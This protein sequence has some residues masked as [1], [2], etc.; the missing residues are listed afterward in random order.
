MRALTETGDNMIHI[1]RLAHGRAPLAQNT[2]FNFSS[3]PQTR[4]RALVTACAL[5]LAALATFP[6]HAGNGGNASGS[7]G[8][9]AGGAGNAGGA[10]ATASGSGQNGQGVGTAGGGAGNTYDRGNGGSTV[11]GGG[12]GSSII[13]DGHTATGGGGGA[14][15]DLSTM[16]NGG[17]GG[18]GSSYGDAP[19][20]GGGGG[21][22]GGLGTL[23]VGAGQSN[24]GAVIGGSGGNGYNGASTGTDGAGGGAGGGGGAGALLGP[25]SGLVNNGNITGGTGGNGGH[26][27]GYG[28]SSGGGGGG[29]VGLIMSDNS[30]LVNFGSIAGGRAGAGDDGYGKGGTA[31]EVTGHATVDNYGSIGGG[32]QNAVNFEGVGNVLNLRAGSN[33]TGSVSVLENA[34]ATI[35]AKDMPQ[36]LPFMTF[37]AKGAQL[38]FDTSGASLSAGVSGGRFGTLI[39]TGANTLTLNY[40]N[41]DTVDSSTDQVVLNN[42]ANVLTSQTWR[43]TVTLGNNVG[44]YSLT[45]PSTSTGI[46]IANLNGGSFNTVLQTS[47]GI[48]LGTASANSLTI[49]GNTLTGNG[50][51]VAGSVAVTTTGVSD[52]SRA[53]TVS[54]TSSFD[55]KGQAINLTHAGNNFTGEVALAGGAVQIVD[56]SALDLGALSVSGLNATSHGALNL[57][58]GTI[59]GAL[60][61]NSNGGNITQDSALHVS[62]TAAANAGTGNVVLTNAGNVFNGAMTLTG[63]DIT[64]STA[65]S[66][67]LDAVTAAGTFNLAAGAVSMTGIGRVAADTL[68]GQV[69]GVANFS[70]YSQIA[71]LGDFT[72]QG[73]QLNNLGALS[74]DGHVDSDTGAINITTDAH[75]LTLASGASLSGAGVTLSSQTDMRVDGQINTTGTALFNAPGNIVVTGDITADTVRSNGLMVIGNGGTTGS[76]SGTL[77]GTY[78]AFNRSDTVVLDGVINQLNQLQQ[79]GSGTLVLNGANTGLS[80]TVVSAGTLLVG[81][82]AHATSTLGTTNLVALNNATV[83]GT[84]T[85]DGSVVVYHGATLAP[86]DAQAIG[87]LTI[88]GDLGLNSGSQL[89]FDLGAASGSDKIQGTSDHLVV[90]GDLQLNGTSISFRDAGGMGPGLYGL[91]Q[92]GGVLTTTNGGITAPA[93]QQLRTYVDDK[94]IVLV[95]TQGLTLDY[96]NANGQASA[97]ALGGGSGTWSVVSSNWTDATG[98][99]TAPMTPQPGFAIFGGSAGTVT[100]DGSAGQ[101]AAQGL[102]FFSDGYRMTGDALALTGQNGAAPILRVSDGATATIDNVLTGNLGLNKTDGGTLVLNG[103]NSYTG[104]TTLSGGIVSVATDANLGAATGALHFDGGTLRITGT[105]FQQT[106][107]DIQWGNQG[108]G[109][110]IAD[111]NNTFTV[112]QAL[113]GGAL[114]KSG[115]GTLVLTGANTY[116]GGTEIAAGTLQGDSLSLQGDIANNATLAFVQDVDGSY[117]GAISGS[118]QL[119]KNG[120]GTLVLA[121]S[122]SYGGGTAIEDGT[123]QGDTRSLQGP[124]VNHASLVFDQATSGIFNG[125]LSGAGD[126]AKIGDGALVLNGNN[127]ATGSFDVQ[128]GTLVMGDDAHA[129]ASYAGTIHIDAGATLGGIGTLGGLSLAGTLS[130]G[131]SVGTLHVTGDAVLQQGSTWHIEAMPDGTADALSVGGKATIQG[132]TVDIVAQDGNWQ[133]RTDYTLL[134]ADGGISGKFSSVTTNLAFLDPVLTYAGNSIRMSLERNDIR[135]DTVGLTANQRAV[136]GAAEALGFGQA[137][138]DALVQQEAATARAGFT[139]LAG[140]IHASTRTAIADNERHVREAIN[141]HLLGAGK[142]IDN[143]QGG[144]AWTSAWGH[145]GHHD[146]DGNA[147]DLSNNGSGLLVGGD[148][149]IGAGSR[150]GAAIGMGQGSASID[151]QRATSHVKDKHLALY[152]ATSMGLFALQGGVVQGWQTIDTR[153]QL[154]FGAFNGRADASYDASTTQAYADGSLRFTTAQGTLAPFANVAWLRLKTDSAN[155]QGGAAALHVMDNSSN[156]TVGTLGLRAQTSLDAQGALRLYASAGWQHAWGDVIPSTQM[157]FVDGSNVFAINGVALARNAGV[158]QGGVQFALSPS[159]SVNATYSGQFA[160]GASDQAARMS[161]TWSF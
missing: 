16:G 27:A 113:A 6:A 59:N 66:T 38:T 155:E 31:L 129:Q 76:V 19:N 34:S 136:A 118:G 161:L 111:A 139:Q 90:T 122:N 133:P 12:G 92:W 22:G 100:V 149:A 83:G 102:Q 24:A 71:H 110:D 157:R 94:Q 1:E 97:T 89:A 84:G 128:A 62:G 99:I 41:V 142:S 152:G 141:E 115:S 52:F 130:P 151:S 42:S 20:A 17:G 63:H 36:T 135:F 65:G 51:V 95:D 104:T 15:G 108:G 43:G 23:F 82:A 116:T 158:V 7:A 87:T 91:I 58:Q 127:G 53:W 47:G 67:T 68:T 123:L 153:R 18:G 77:T 160:S 49:I 159:L 14:G 117:A 85:I 144:T 33:I 126:I 35:A 25:G 124:I 96:W 5:A 140:E 26:G 107:R 132:G 73:L 88:N 121:G 156:Q 29:G 56:Q 120:A 50:T 10:G 46:S 44:F 70:S 148:V 147:S 37:L 2:A 145:W 101:V 114:V 103:I 112:S 57:G 98:Q 125:T 93:G 55:A 86:G 9:A 28:G 105:S 134:S 13:P 69:T 150:I 30:T 143:G 61:A 146:G 8:G 54:G 106:A 119:V 40:L 109:F 72:S 79:S 131:N 39:T 21:G 64:V 138:Y 4:R 137:V 32:G 74:I 48:S 80:S 81:D 11:A 154:D 60:V 75:T 45:T 3:M 78:M